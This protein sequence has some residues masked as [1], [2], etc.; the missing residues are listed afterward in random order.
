MF[1]IIYK[2]TNLLDGKFYIG[3]HSTHDI[4][5]GY[6]GSGKYLKRAIVK[7][8]LE[9]FSREVLFQFNSKS[10]M[11]DKERELVTEEFITTN[12]TYNLKVGGS[13]GNPGIVGA[14]KGMVHTDETK[15]KIRLARSLQKPFSDETRKKISENNGMKREEVRLKLAASI[16]G[17]KCTHTHREKVAE[18]NRGRILVND[19][20]KA[21]RI[22][23]EDLRIYVDLGWKRGGMPR[24]HI[25]QV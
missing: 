7:Y 22:K 24:K 5:D 8:G 23:L 12:N 20:T 14:F 2:T 11:F 21:I 1:H 10:E 19:G 15:Q 9:N 6:M 17:K 18:A 25:S 3:A 4:N 13:G 16:R